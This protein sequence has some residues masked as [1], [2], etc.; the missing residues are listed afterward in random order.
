MSGNVLLVDDDKS[1]CELLEAGLQRRGFTVAWRTNA[2]AALALLAEQ[3]FDAVVTDLNMPGFNGLQFCER[4]GQN[5]PDIPVVVITAFGSLEAAVAAI[6]VG[7][8]D[9][10]T[11]PFEVDALTLT[12]NRAVEARRL[13]EEVKRLRAVVD[14]QG[15]FDDLL[16]QSPAMRK[17]YDLIKRVA[18]SE[19]TVLVTG[20]SG[21]GKELVARA[22]HVRSRRKA[23]AFVALNCAAVPETLMESELFGHAKGAFTDA[24]TAR[25][26][27][28][29]QAQGGTLFL[30]EI[31]EMPMA[32]QPKLLRVLQERSF[33]P[34]GADAEVA[35]DVRLVTA[36]N[37]DLESA[38]EE[39]RF[40]EDLYYRINV[41][42]I[43][44]PPLRARGSDVLLLAQNFCGVYAARAGK[45][46]LGMSPAAAQRLVTYHWPGNIR[47][48]QN[49]IE[50]A[51]ALTGFEQ[52]T[53]E[54]LPEK[55]RNYRTSHV[56]VATDD[57]TELVPLEEVERR[58][59]LKVVEAVG[60]NKTLA[61]RSLGLDRKTLYRKLERYGHVS[62]PDDE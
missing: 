34:V 33:R 52:V 30:D 11:K 37:R 61:A 23:A 19:S 26:G 17:V 44:L 14:Q 2:E 57:P 24:R 22:I 10:I 50:R 18:D 41:I 4:V 32:I 60:G 45:R 54:D 5:R 31:G 42:H 21:T 40:R 3:E 29:Q 38:V 12:L 20:E 51:V 46:V 35:L 49:C 58:Y 59:I 48:L 8:Y 13:K 39:G 9:F 25:A 55:I 1:M 47:E 28:L 6:R 16:G 27:L 43:P 36:T 7:A 53:V 56:V 15:R 62:S